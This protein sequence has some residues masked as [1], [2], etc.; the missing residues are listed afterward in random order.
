M[1]SSFMNPQR[2]RKAYGLVGTGLRGSSVIGP[3]ADDLRGLGYLE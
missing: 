1:P 3:Q 2:A